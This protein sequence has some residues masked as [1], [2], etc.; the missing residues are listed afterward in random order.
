MIGTKWLAAA[1]LAVFSAASV[2][3]AGR[4]QIDSLASVNRINP[5]V[6]TVQQVRDMFGPPARGPMTFRNKGISAIEYEVDDAGF[7]YVI[8]ISYGN[9][10]IV[11]EVV[12]KRPAGGL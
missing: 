8:S 10:G 2:L 3:A 1:F 5:G 7:I 6:T 4:G 9:D 12:K 11:R